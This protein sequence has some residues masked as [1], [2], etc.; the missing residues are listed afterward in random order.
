MLG[1][2]LHGQARDGVEVLAEKLEVRAAEF[3]HVVP[4]ST[5]V[6]QYEEKSCQ[7]NFAAKCGQPWFVP[8]YSGSLC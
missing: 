1:E 4:S 5:C 8:L 7:M 3:H 6:G 2:P